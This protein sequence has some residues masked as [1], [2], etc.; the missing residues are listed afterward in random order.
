MKQHLSQSVRGVFL[1]VIEFENNFLSSY[2]SE[3]AVENSNTI[4]TPYDLPNFQV[5]LYTNWILG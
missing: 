3:P 4:E 1:G 2:D 5:P